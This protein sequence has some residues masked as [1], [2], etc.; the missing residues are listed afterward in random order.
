MVE[1][2]VGFEQGKSTKM[3]VCKAK[4]CKHNEHMRCKLGSI[5]ISSSGSCEQFSVEGWSKQLG[6]TV[7]D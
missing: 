6:R 1:K 3:R 5:N 7:L 2:D 4:D